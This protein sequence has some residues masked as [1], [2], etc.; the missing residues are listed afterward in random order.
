[1][2]YI[3]FVNGLRVRGEFNSVQEVLTALDGELY[4]TLVIRPDEGR[5][6]AVLPGGI[7]TPHFSSQ[8]GAINCALAEI[9]AYPTKYIEVKEC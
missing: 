7:T 4:G 6:H 1:M 2:K 9:N 3:A 5:Y 8:T